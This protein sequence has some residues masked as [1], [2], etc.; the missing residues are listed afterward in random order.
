VSLIARVLEANGIAT[1]IIGSALDIVLHCGIPRYVHSDLP[2]GNPCGAPY[3]KV[4]QQSIMDTAMGLLSQAHGSNA[5]MRSDA[6][7]P[8]DNS[9][10]DDYSRV[11]DS[12]RELLKLKGEARRRQQTE[13]KANGKARAAMIADS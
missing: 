11:D 5:V 3:D 1:V 12:N 9:W 8:G 6:V 4:M 2:L 13:H 10:R 7:W